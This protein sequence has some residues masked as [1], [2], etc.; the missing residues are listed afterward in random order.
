MNEGGLKALE[1]FTALQGHAE[2]TGEW[3]EITQAKIDAFAEATLDF[4][5]IHVNPEAAARGPFGTTIAHGL[6]TLSLVPHLVLHLCQHPEASEGTTGGANI[7]F[8]RVRMPAPVPVN[9][10]IRGHVKFVSVEQKG[11]ALE[12]T[13]EVTVELEG[14]ERPA[15]V[16]E[17]I[18][19][20]FYA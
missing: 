9:T 3:Y 5:E 17:W 8:N 14:A 13:R 16:A 1:Y 11:D 10:R 4:A 15:L 6:F 2:G 7:G 18:F 12:F 20:T 19:R